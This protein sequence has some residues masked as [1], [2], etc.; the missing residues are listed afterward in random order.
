MAAMTHLINE[1]TLGKQKVREKSAKS[2][3]ASASRER[4][5][6]RR[7][8]ALAQNERSQRRCDASDGEEHLGV[9]Q[10]VGTAR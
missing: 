4:A 6:V 9:Q 8:S 10:Q 2:A 7:T 5:D 3:R 1:N